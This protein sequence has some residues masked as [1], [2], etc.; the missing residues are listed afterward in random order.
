MSFPPPIK[1]RYGSIW[2]P[3]NPISAD[4]AV[5]SRGH[6]CS[7]LPAEDLL[8]P[9]LTSYLKTFFLLLFFK[10]TVNLLIHH[11]LLVST[12][13]ALSSQLFFSLPQPLWYVFQAEIT[14]LAVRLL[15]C[16][17][18]TFR[19][20]RMFHRVCAQSSRSCVTVTPVCLYLFLCATLLLCPTYPAHDCLVILRESLDI[21]LQ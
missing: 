9:S 10:N 6:H 14:D 21:H 15:N 18:F 16:Y 4:L 1:K 2:C 13:T 3:L 11:I 5:A 12:C 17:F 19:G 7:S 8:S 20:Y